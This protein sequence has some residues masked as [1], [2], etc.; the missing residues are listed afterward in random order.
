MVREE[1]CEARRGQ[2]KGMPKFGGQQHVNA[3]DVG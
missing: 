3:E 2:R 1:G